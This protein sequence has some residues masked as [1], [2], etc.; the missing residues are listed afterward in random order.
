M[1]TV[2]CRLRS[3]TYAICKICNNLE[4]LLLALVSTVYMLA[5]LALTD[6]SFRQADEMELVFLT[7]S[8]HDHSR[9][10]CKVM[11]S[12]RTRLVA[13]LYCL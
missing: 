6:P 13:S 4:H 2:R 1:I 7:T 11:N 12:S 10:Y 5:R 8:A 3:N 9:Q